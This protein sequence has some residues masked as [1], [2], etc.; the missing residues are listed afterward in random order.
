MRFLDFP[1]EL[2]LRILTFL[3]ISSIVSFRL[4]C[5]ALKRT[6]DL[7]Q[8]EQWIFHQVAYRNGWIDK[9]E[10][11]Y[12][13]VKERYSR[14]ALDGTKRKRWKSFC[15]RRFQIDNA[16][17]GTPKSRCRLRQYHATEDSVHRIKVDEERG[18]I[19][20]TSGNGGLLVTGLDFCNPLWSLS[21]DYVRG[22]AHCEYSNGY[23]IFDRFSG[24]KE[25]WRLKDDI[26]DEHL[27]TLPQPVLTPSG[28]RVRAAL[29]PSSMWHLYP[30]KDPIN[31]VP[32]GVVEESLPDGAQIRELISAEEELKKLV[33]GGDE[34]D[35]AD[36]DESN[37]EDDDESDD[38]DGDEDQEAQGPHMA[39]PA[40]GPPSSDEDA[41]PDEGF[42]FPRISLH[43][44]L[45]SAWKNQL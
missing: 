37:D 18:F 44:G 23:L 26:V 13:E 35:N 3:P 20:N 10:E 25:V 4:V 32:K 2:I 33:F 21:E 11:G 29:F 5:R 9:L 34:S 27:A 17:K 22:F 41:D 28:E 1:V 14:K 19:I 43:R 15:K 38:E 7:K 8:N 45:C 36:D 30:F 6:I 39:M 16:W 40:T 31:W 12:E 24:E 42:S